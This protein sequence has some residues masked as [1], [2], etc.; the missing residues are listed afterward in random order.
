MTKD[1]IDILEI[2]VLCFAMM[3]FMGSVSQRDDK[4]SELMSRLARISAYYSAQF[5]TRR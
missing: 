2:I 5:P 1:S 4:V 3:V